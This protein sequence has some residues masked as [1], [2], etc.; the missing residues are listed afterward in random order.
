ELKKI[1]IENFRSLRK[2]EFELGNYGVIFGKNNE[3]KSNILKAL[4]R[5]WEILNYLKSY[6]RQY[7]KKDGIKL[8]TFR[9][10]DRYLNKNINI[11]N[12]IPIEIRNKKTT[13]KCASI[14]LV[15][16]LLPKEVDELNV[17]LTSS[18]TATNYLE[19]CVSYDRDLNCKVTVKLKEGGKVVSVLKNTFI[20][21]RYLLENFSINYIPSIRTEEHAMQI[22]ENTIGQ[23]F[24]VLEKSEDYNKAL[25]KINE[26]Q[27]DLLKDISET[28]EP[29]LKKYLGSIK[30]V[31][32]TS[33]RNN[34][35]RN[36][37]N[38]FNI[39]ID[40]GKRTNLED[41]GDGIKSLVA[42]SLLQTIKSESGL[43]MI[44]EPEAHLHS[45]AITELK[46]KI[47]NES[48]KQ[49]VLVA[50]HHQVFVDRNNLQNNYL[51]S[52]GRLKSEKNIRNIRSELGVSM[53]ENLINSE[54]IILVE[55]ETDKEL[56]KKYIKNTDKKINQLID[57]NKIV[58]DALSGTKNLESKLSFYNSCLCKCICILDNDD[59]GR[60]ASRIVIEKGLIDE[61]FVYKIP[62]NGKVNSEIEDLYDE[63]FLYNEI[64]NLFGL[65]NSISRKSMSENMKFSE[66]IRDILDTYGKDFNKENK[67][68]LKRVLANQ[69]FSNKNVEY[70]SDTGKS[71]FNPILD[72]IYS[73]F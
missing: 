50:S 30:T 40:D 3:G 55:G 7:N 2:I 28:I 12:D 66:K 47:Q 57:E 27:E 20:T 9:F 18:T 36:I 45:G 60:D 33:S 16:E 14:N 35:I 13:R 64:D 15:F 31:E 19:I 6:E 37:R 51:L 41:K 24:E 5:F 72:A 22:I 65:E 11:E 73:Y 38:T 8:H 54:L 63:V 43:L 46:M 4:K 56:L 34:L 44:D 71:F 61:K 17:V 52:S 26:L 32:L 1:N 29:D 58:I 48:N 10:R 42:L 25:E 53:G 39:I 59:S 62:L 67:E 70:L 21:L 49:Q 69:S 68:K 23:K